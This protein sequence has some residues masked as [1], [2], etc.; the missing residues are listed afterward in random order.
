MVDWPKGD[1]GKFFNGDSYI[2]LNTYTEEDSD[3]SACM[4]QSEHPAQLNN[5][6]CLM[7]K[8]KLVDG[9]IL[10]FFP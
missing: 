7:L 10:F 2:I 3:V 6:I 8:I 5:S 1:Y 4:L 9:I